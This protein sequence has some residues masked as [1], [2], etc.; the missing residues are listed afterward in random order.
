MD[1]AALA[2]FAA[3]CVAIE[4]TPGPNMVWLALVS[5]TQGRRPGFAAVTGVAVGLALVGVAAALGLGAVVANS[6]AVY[7]TLRVAGIAYLLWLAVEAWRSGAQRKS[8]LE[9]AGI[10]LGENFRRGIITNLL[11]PKA[12][13]FYIVVLP[14]FPPPQPTLA[15]TLVL[16]AIYVAVATAIH[17]AVV[18]AAGTAR[19]ALGQRQKMQ[20]VGRSAA[21]VLVILAIWLWFK[22]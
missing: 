18:M 6:P 21:G 22:T 12:F 5:I 15:D 1:I 9:G 14:A 7:Q 8:G 17:G 2:T 10:T 11:N 4:L 16:C 3:A 13:L 20:I 19:A